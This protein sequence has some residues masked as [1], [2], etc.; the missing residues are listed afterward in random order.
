MAS[1]R[2]NDAKMFSDIADGIAIIINS[3][4]GIYYGMNGFGTIVYE[5]LE[6]GVSVESILGE[7]RKNPVA[8]QDMEQRLKAFVDALKKFEIIVDGDEENAEAS[9]DA[10]ACQADDFELKVEEF[11]DAQE[12]LLADPIHEVKN[13]TGWQPAKDALET[14]ENA[15][16]EKL[17]KKQ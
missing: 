7:L 10:A 5:N 9:L 3:E 4:T 8:P 2:L 13:E 6:K 14:D 1:Y 15:V 11:N 17:D 12:L 16:Q